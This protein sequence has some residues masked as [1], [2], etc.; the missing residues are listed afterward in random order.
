MTLELL[1]PKTIAKKKSSR[2]RSGISAYNSG[3]SRVGTQGN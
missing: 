1:K 2:S 3:R